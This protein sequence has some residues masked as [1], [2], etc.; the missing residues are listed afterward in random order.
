LVSDRYRAHDAPF[1]TELRGPMLFFRIVEH[2][3]RLLP[4]LILTVDEQIA[5]GGRVATRWSARATGRG[6]GRVVESRGVFVAHVSRGK[7]VESWGAWDSVSLL[8]QLDALPFDF[9][10]RPTSAMRTR[11]FGLRSGPPVVL[12]PPGPLPGW[13][14]WRRIIPA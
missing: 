7:V 14:T 10:E 2:Y 8:R 12:V 9:G 11:E 4:D 3:K 6:S 13:I 5:D 1:E